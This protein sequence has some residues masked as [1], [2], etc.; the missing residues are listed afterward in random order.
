MFCMECGMQLADGKAKFCGNCGTKV[1]SASKETDPGVEVLPP[2]FVQ[3]TLSQ[4]AMESLA[5]LKEKYPTNIG[6]KPVSK[7][8]T[9]ES[10]EM[11]I[12]VMDK[13]KK[14]L[15]RAFP[16]DS[17]LTGCLK[18]KANYN[19]TTKNWMDS[20][21]HHF[22]GNI[23]FIPHIMGRNGLEPISTDCSLEQIESMKIQ[24]KSALK[25]Y[26]MAKGKDRQEIVQKFKTQNI[27]EV[28]ESDE[29]MPKIELQ[30]PSSKCGGKSLS[31]IST[32]QSN[33]VV[34]SDE[35]MPK[36]R[37][38]KPSSKCGGKSL[39]KISTMQSDDVVESDEEMPKIRLQKPSSKCGGKSL[40]K[41]S[42]MQSD[43]SSKCG[44]KSLS[45]MS[46]MQS[47][48][49]SKCGGKSLP[50]ISTMQS[51]DVVESDEEMSNMR[52]QKP[53][54][55][56]GGKSLPKMSAMQSDDSSKCGGKSLPKI[57]TMQSDDIVESDV[58]LPKVPLPVVE[59]DVELPQ[60]SLPSSKCSGENMP[61]GRK[62]KSSTM[63]SDDLPD[64]C[65]SKEE[66]PC[67]KED[68]L[69]DREVEKFFDLMDKKIKRKTSVFTFACQE[70]N[71][72]IL[73][74]SFYFEC[75]S[76]ESCMFANCQ[77][78]FK[79]EECHGI[80]IRDIPDVLLLKEAEYS[81]DDT[82][83]N[84]GDVHLRGSVGPVFH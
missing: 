38:Q 48:D 23:D 46:A 8:R 79:L 43:D 81:L 73:P 52:L 78:S 20:L 70:I 1:P 18:I 41:I 58:E 22:R 42:T 60:V 65:S 67:I 7:K 47:D 2:S 75:V 72:E 62:I 9:S 76:T 71:P 56:C 6:H 3:G 69:M 68:E 64:L 10:K 26:A 4:G 5:K 51:N 50:K 14:A 16:S 33:D 13:K 82:L 11:I 21:K 35:E 54:S 80:N 45:K 84:Y 36:I 39:P 12:H 40:P 30:K 28:M 44:V 37:L 63:Q 25:I 74:P 57:S 29:E 55:K 31:K 61:L 24:K 34:E 59:S 27:Q 19:Q 77:H 17:G 15:K 49:S 32:M 66:S 83:T 53:S